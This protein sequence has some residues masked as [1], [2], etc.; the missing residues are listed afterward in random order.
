M[1]TIFHDSMHKNI[2]GYCELQSRILL[3]KRTEIF[4]QVM[5]K[6]EW[7]SYNIKKNKKGE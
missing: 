6:G 5:Q 1:L 3:I 7:P 4:N 2:R